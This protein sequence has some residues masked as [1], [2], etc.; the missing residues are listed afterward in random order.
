MRSSSKAPDCM[1]H[2]KAGTVQTL[3]CMIIADVR[4]TIP[5]TEGLLTSHQQPAERRVNRADQDQRTLAQQS[6]C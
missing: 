1:T 3:L 5:I 6:Q 4:V 2:K